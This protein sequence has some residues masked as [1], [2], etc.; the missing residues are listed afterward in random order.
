MKKFVARIGY[1]DYAVEQD[2]AAE[3]LAIASRAVAVERLKWGEPYYKRKEQE[4]IV[5]SLQIA[6]VIEEPRSDSDVVSV[7]EPPPKPEFPF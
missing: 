5:E 2:D 7:V 6:E 4:Q 3:L 1:V